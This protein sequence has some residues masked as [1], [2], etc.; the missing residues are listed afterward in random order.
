MNVSYAVQQLINLRQSTGTPLHIQG[1]LQAACHA[2]DQVTLLGIQGR[3]LYQ[4]EISDKLNLTRDFKPKIIPSRKQLMA[5]VERPVRR[6]QSTFDAPYYCLFD[7]LRLSTAPKNC[8]KEFDILHAHF[9]IVP[10]GS[11]LL[12]RRLNKPLVIDA[13]ADW[14]D[15]ITADG[16]EIAPSF[17][18]WARFVQE[19]CLRQAA[20][21]T[22]VSAELKQH[23]V[24]V[25]G[26]PAERIHV[27]PNG[28]DVDKFAPINGVGIKNKWR[29]KLKIGDHT[30][31][32]MFVG[33]FYRRHG[34]D[35]L[36][37]SFQLV[38]NKVP[39]SVLVLVG[40]GKL[41]PQIDGLVQEL[42]LMKAVRLTGAVPHD[43]IPSILQIADVTA[44]PAEERYLTGE[45][46][47]LQT[48]PLK[49]LEYM[50]A[51]KACVAT[52]S[53]QQAEV[54]RDHET[55]VL[56]PP[57]DINSLAEAIIFLFENE[58]ERRRMAVNARQ[59]VVRHHSW[60]H[61]GERLKGI[62]EQVL[63]EACQA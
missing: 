55:G 41:R 39:G 54:I 9:D 20:A 14:F 45:I 11:A 40:D 34:I 27:L 59:F 26:L 46:K 51:E 57:G 16:L 30:H 2:A 62:Y 10:L 60:Q 21:I 36:V 43:D 32:V 4:V 6:L 53:G 63:F 13:E 29:E 17:E 49:L 24:Y 33:G 56:V 12:S 22:V 35:Q 37:R 19:R 1:V 8:I 58:S 28:V 42:G 61:Y 48:S 31:V 38:H 44:S 18:R 52:A 47:P 3:D 15:E 5:P 25:W 23:F 7:T 50:A